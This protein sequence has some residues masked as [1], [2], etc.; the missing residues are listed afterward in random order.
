MTKTD[1][2]F[3]V[4]YIRFVYFAAHSTFVLS[5]GVA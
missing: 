4:F 3:P 5:S 1:L 2:T